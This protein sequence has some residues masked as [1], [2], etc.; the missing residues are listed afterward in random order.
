MATIRCVPPT[1]VRT[2]CYTCLTP[3][4]LY[5]TQQ[6]LSGSTSHIL[7]RHS[8]CIAKCSTNDS[9]I[10]HTPP[11]VAY[12][13]PF[14][15]VEDI[16]DS[17]RK[18]GIDLAVDGRQPDVSF[19]LAFCGNFGQKKVTDLLHVILTCYSMI[20]FGFMERIQCKGHFVGQ[21]QRTI[22]FFFLEK[23]FKLFAELSK[24]N[25]SCFAVNPTPP[26]WHFPCGSD[27]ARST[28]QNEIFGSIVYQF[29]V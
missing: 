1:W 18:G 17:R 25:I 16:E 4:T 27:Y 20:I 26:Y 22:F 8:S 7:V 28:L 9:S 12:C 6:D 24:N 2:A 14:I 5:S 11:I 10:F 15:I 29:L 23:G 21:E 19:L 3:W 13:A